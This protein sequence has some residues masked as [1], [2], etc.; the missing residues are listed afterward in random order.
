MSNQVSSERPL[1]TFVLL[2]YNQEQYV[3]AAIQGALAQDYEPLEI[4]L[5]DDCSSDQTFDI[6]QELASS[7]QGPHRVRLRQSEVNLG[8]SLHLAA[9]SK[10]SS[11]ELLVLASGDDISVPTRT[12]ELANAWLRHGKPTGVLHSKLLQFKE[13]IAHGK[14][15]SLR[16]D[17]NRPVDIRWLLKG[18]GIPF[19]APTSAFS[20]TIFEEFPQMPG[21]TFIEDGPLSARALLVGKVIAVDKCLVFQRILKQ[22]AGRGYSILDPIKWNQLIIS[23]IISCVSVIRDV[24]G[25]KS[26]TSEHRRIQRAHAKIARRLSSF[27]MSGKSDP[28]TLSKLVFIIRFALCYPTSQRFLAKLHQALSLVGWEIKRPL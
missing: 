18:K 3:R 26:S 19:M 7:Y 17:V 2:A 14:E 25:L 21:G 9:V 16:Y 10:A 8:T 12:S 6:M 20:K 1:V 23:R 13:D 15:V 24:E 27:L 4:I 22:T 11:G 28:G 5:S